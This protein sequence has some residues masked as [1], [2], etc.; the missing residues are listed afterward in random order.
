MKKLLGLAL[1]IASIGFVAPSVEAKAATPGVSPAASVA[2][3]AAVQWENRGR[4]QWGNRRWGNRPVRVA[5]Q[6]RFVR[7]GRRLFRE[8]YQTTYFAN[9]R[10]QTRL[11]SRVRV[12]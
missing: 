4:R 2:T 10:T 9:G 6:T 11:I 7:S 3:P 1:S 12:R 5:T 8:T